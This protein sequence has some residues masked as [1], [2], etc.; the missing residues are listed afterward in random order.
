[1]MSYLEYGCRF[2][3]DKINFSINTDDSEIIGTTLTKEFESAAKDLGLSEDVL[4]ET[5]FNSARS[6]FLPSEEKA[7]LLAQLAVE[8]AKYKTG[9]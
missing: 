5:V 1:M 6:S 8:I 3:E 4:I 7:A 2:A 9:Q